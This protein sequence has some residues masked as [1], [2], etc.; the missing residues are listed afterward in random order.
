[1]P[2]LQVS[3][4]DDQTC[5]VGEIPVG[6]VFRGTI[7]D[8]S[9]LFLKAAGAVILLKEPFTVTPCDH[10]GQPVAAHTVVTGY[11]EPAAKLTISMRPVKKGQSA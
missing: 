8:Q 1:M 5:K 11:A 4:L 7:R 10:V 2:R 6:T 9:G 3:G